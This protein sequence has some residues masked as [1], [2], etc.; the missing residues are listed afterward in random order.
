MIINKKHLAGVAAVTLLA[1]G[2]VLYLNQPNAVP[3]FGSLPT[4][5][6]EAKAFT[7]PVH[8]YSI[9]DQTLLRAIQTH[10][11][12]QFNRALSVA[13]NDNAQIY[14]ESN[15]IQRFQAVKQAVIKRGVLSADSDVVKNIDWLIKALEL[16]KQE[17]PKFQMAL[18]HEIELTNADDIRRYKKITNQL[19]DY[20]ARRDAKHKLLAEATS[21]HDHDGIKIDKLINTLN[22]K[23]N[24]RLSANG[25]KQRN[26][27]NVTSFL[28]QLSLSIKSEY[29]RGVIIE[30]PYLKI[31]DTGKLFV[32]DNK[33]ELSIAKPLVTDF[34]AQHNKEIVNY[35]ASELDLQMQREQMSSFFDEAKVRYGKYPVELKSDLKIIKATIR[36]NTG[37]VYDVTTEQIEFKPSYLISNKWQAYLAKMGVSNKQLVTFAERANIIVAVDNKLSMAAAADARPAKVQSDGSVVVPNHALNGKGVVIV[38]ISGNSNTPWKA[39]LFKLDKNGKLSKT[40]TWSAS[41]SVPYYQSDLSRPIYNIS[42]Y[43]S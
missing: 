14:L 25:I 41:L 35:K 15:S 16:R 42:K 17:F 3:F 1:G 43:I 31:N 20:K 33:N 38:G 13:F 18:K 39:R 4:N 29:H 5:G 6:L 30:L 2:M 27:L 22:D 32:T 7:I 8:G 26:I 23:I 11:V 28:T 12:E 24:D 21:R 37:G 34:L 36:D 9:F 40:P 19:S 10:E